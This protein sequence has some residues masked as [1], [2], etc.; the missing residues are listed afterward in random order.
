MREKGHHMC[1]PVSHL[2]FMIFPWHTK[3]GHWGNWESK[4]LSCQPWT[5]GYLWEMDLSNEQLL[6][7]NLNSLI[8]LELNVCFSTGKHRLQSDPQR[9]VTSAYRDIN[10]WLGWGDSH[11]SQSLSFSFKGDFC[12]WLPLMVQDPKTCGEAYF[13]RLKSREEL[14]GYLVM[15]QIPGAFP[16]LSTLRGKF[17]L[18]FTVS[19]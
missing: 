3:L 19:K 7:P 2:F 12:P 14:N 9:S 10:N 6:L 1:G 13:T 5:L 17:S 16:T 8:K 11:R 15:W 18:L 4:S